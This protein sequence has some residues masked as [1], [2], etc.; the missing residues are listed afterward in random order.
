MYMYMYTVKT[1]KYEYMYAYCNADGF[2]Y[3]GWICI[4]KMFLVFSRCVN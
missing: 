3:Y 2:K 1:K 4:C